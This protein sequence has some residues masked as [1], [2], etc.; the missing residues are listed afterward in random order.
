MSCP[1]KNDIWKRL[2]KYVGSETEAY[3]VFNAHGN[4]VPSVP[5]LSELKGIIK[6]NNTVYSDKKAASM[7][8]ILN[9]YN[10]KYNTSHKIRYSKKTPSSEKAELVMNF[11]PKNVTNSIPDNSL[12]T[13]VK[14]GDSSVVSPK[15]YDDIFIQDGNQY[16]SGGNVFSSYEDAENYL[17]ESKAFRDTKDKSLMPMSKMY[18]KSISEILDYIENNS[19]SEYSRILANKF[20]GF[21]NN[22]TIEILDSDSY[23]LEYQKYLDKHHKDDSVKSPYGTNGVYL[24]IDN[25]ILILDS[26][27]ERTFLHEMAHAL[28]FNTLED[29][30]LGKDFEEYFNE[31]KSRL[32]KEGFDLK[33]YGFTNKFEFLSEIFSNSSFIALLKQ[34]KPI[35]SAEYKNIWQELLNFFKKL[36]GS[37]NNTLYDEALNYSIEVLNENDK[38]IHVYNNTRNI[39]PLQ[40]QMDD[41][42]KLIKSLDRATRLIMEKSKILSK[43][44]VEYASDISKMLGYL[45][46]D[47][48]KRVAKNEYASAILSFI[49]EV[50]MG[51]I[52]FMTDTIAEY[53]HGRGDVNIDS[54]YLNRMD[55]A[56]KLY[57][58]IIDDISSVIRDD[59]N[60]KFYADLNAKVRE[61]I[62]NFKDRLGQVKDFVSQET[63]R[64]AIKQIKNGMGDNLNESPEKLLEYIDTDISKMQV[65]FGSLKNVP[66]PVLQMIYKMVIFQHYNTERAALSVGKSLF[67]LQLDMEKSGYKDMSIFH[68]KYNGKKTGYIIS[69]VNWGEFYDKKSEAFNKVLEAM[70]KFDYKT[71]SEIPNRNELNEDERK[72]FDA[73]YQKY[74][75]PFE[76]KY[77]REVNGKLYDNP[78]LNKDFSKIKNTP[79]LFKYY[80]AVINTMRESRR[81]LP[82]AYSHNRSSMYLMPQ[83]RNDMMETI[84]SKEGVFKKIGVRVKEKFISTDQDIEFGME[85]IIKDESGNVAKLIPIHYAHKIDNPSDLSDDVTSLSVAYYQM[86]HKFDGMSKKAEDIKVLQRSLI[87][88]DWKKG[89]TGGKFNESNLAKMLSNF[90]DANV[91]GKMDKKL[92]VRIPG[93]DINV[94]VT[95]T[96]N[97]ILEHVRKVNLFMNIPTSV[98]GAIKSTI[99]F[100]LDVIANKYVTPESAKWAEIEFDKNIASLIENVGKRKKSGKLNLL[101]EY[102]GVFGTIDEMFSRMQMTD[103]LSRFHRD[104]FTYIT[105]SIPDIKIRGMLSLA[106][107]DNYRLVNGKFISKREF[108]R[109]YSNKNSK[110]YKPQL[111][112]SDYKNDTLYNAYEIKNNK[113]T[114]KSKYKKYV[115]QDL[116]NT[117]R[118]I[119]EERGAVMTGQLTRHDRSDLA[120]SVF[121]RFLFLHRNWLVQGVTERFKRTIKNPITNEN[122]EGYYRSVASLIKRIIVEEGNI[123]QK[124]G[125]WH[126]L[127]DYERYNVIKT[128]GDIGFTLMVMGLSAIINGLAEDEPDEY[129]LQYLAFQ[130]NRIQLEQKALMG[131]KEPISIINSPTAAGSFITTISSIRKLLTNWD[132]IEYGP[133]EDMYQIEKAIIKNTRLKNLWEI[134]NADA[135]K[136]KNKYLTTQIL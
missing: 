112:W 104:D 123:R 100:T 50:S 24:P 116:E 106:V 110:K 36:F 74:Y 85:D 95:K 131:F 61:E 81:M 117:V 31:V 51:E 84:K 97:T 76:R 8:Y 52:E 113:F 78:P 108:D 114:V 27:S 90:L 30:Q 102:N 71:Y 89:N 49:K 9:K 7:N 70:K 75:K 111:K 21:N 121:G 25:K 54:G 39:P 32:E 86:A 55:S 72:V 60:D 28:S 65:S 77:M 67:D 119:I 126:K 105:Y 129:W 3:R 128:L 130:I 132:R 87:E 37:D 2:V 12:E 99:D 11:M 73:A 107:Y 17:L 115:N 82:S 127:E 44:S 59:L 136:Q 57:E 88:R 29:T 69:S 23:I 45:A 98:S 40:E 120:R 80:S 46:E 91:Y 53:D 33:E 79:V 94:N 5:K 63:R 19:K 16:I 18:G 83:I 20:K 124:L 41:I 93:T 92:E 68:E 125:V 96:L 13:K 134:R 26:S 10:Q 118:F 38:I 64:N 1:V 62:K 56:V 43:S 109:T 135:I 22:T 42:D 122:E 66:D 48:N 6:F 133:Y 14:S 47:I 34:H 103:K 15:S 101:L 35:N 58:K 4:K